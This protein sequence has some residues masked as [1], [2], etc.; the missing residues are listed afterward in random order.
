MSL[1]RNDIQSMKMVKESL[2]PEGLHQALS[3]QEMADL[4]E[5]LKN[6]RRKA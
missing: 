6:Q 2:M 4:L 5:F 1:K 3:P